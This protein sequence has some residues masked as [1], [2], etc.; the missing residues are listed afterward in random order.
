MMMKT[1]KPMLM[2]GQYKLDA[3]DKE[4]VQ[5]DKLIKLKDQLEERQKLQNS[6]PRLLQALN[7]PRQVRHGSVAFLIQ[8]PRDNSSAAAKEAQ[9]QVGFHKKKPTF[10]YL[11]SLNQLELDDK[12]KT[13]FGSL[14]RKDIPH[15]ALNKF[16]W[17][18]IQYL[19]ETKKEQIDLLTKDL[20]MLMHEVK[21]ESKVLNAELLKKQMTL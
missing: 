16:K 14:S 20:K 8:K 7:K 4:R 12:M 2:A 3:R 1:K 11:S 17:K 18:T 6:K 19:L 5:I 15:D 10:Q 21:E 9:T 13:D